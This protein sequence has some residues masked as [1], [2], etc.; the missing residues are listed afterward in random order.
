MTCCDLQTVPDQTLFLGCSILDF[1]TSLQWGDGVSDLNVN[2]VADFCSGTRIYY[3]SC[4]NVQSGTY[5]DLGFVAED[6][7]ERTDGTKYSSCIKESVSDTKLR[8]R[9]EIVGCPVLFKY[10]SF[11]YSG[12]VSDWNKNNSAS[13]PTYR[14]KIVDPRLVLEGV[15]LIIGDYTGSV[16]GTIASGLGGTGEP[17]TNI[18]N[19]YGY[20]EQFGLVCPSYSQCSPG[21]YNLTSVCPTA[22]DG[23]SFGSLVGGF[24]GSLLNN[25]GMP[26]NYII[27]GFNFLANATPVIQ[28]YW[29]PYGRVSYFSNDISVLN[30]SGCGLIEPDTGSSYFANK[31]YY[32][33]DLTELPAFPDNTYRISGTSISLLDLITKASQD[34]NFDFY[35]ELL[36]VKDVST[37]YGGN[38]VAKIIKLRT[39]NRYTQPSLDKICSFIES[40]DCILESS[41]GQE[42]RNETVSKFIIGGKKRTIYQAFSGAN[43]DGGS[44]S[45]ITSID[46]Y[47]GGLRTDSG[48]NEIDDMVLPY[49]GTDFNGDLIV[50]CQVSGVW[51]FAAPTWGIQGELQII[52]FSGAS[53]TITEN[54]LRA[55]SKDYSSWEGYAAAINSD[56][57]KTIY[58]SGGPAIQE[59]QQAATTVAGGKSFL[60]HDIVNPK[61]SKFRENIDPPSRRFQEDKEAIY[62]WIRSYATDFYGR[63]F[64]VRVPFTCV[65][66]DID[67]LQPII[68][69]SPTNDGGW[70]EVSSVLNLPNGGPLTLGQYEYLNFFRDSTNKI[71]PFVQFND[72]VLKSIGNLNK[73][74]Y[75]YKYDVLS[76]S[77]ASGNGPPSGSPSS[78]ICYQ[79]ALTDILYV[80]SF[81]QWLPINNSCVL[82]GSG[83]PAISGAQTPETFCPVYYNVENGDV[84]IA[85]NSTYT[86]ATGVNVGSWNITASVNLYVKAQV[87][88]EYV[89]HDKS[90]YFAPRVV[91]EI[92]EAVK[93]VE[94]TPAY[95]DGTN[96][97]LEAVADGE[98]ELQGNSGIANATHAVGGDAAFMN[99]DYQASLIYAAAIPLEHNTLT[100]GPWYNPTITGRVEIVNDSNLVPWRYNGYTNL[101]L[102]G[103]NLANESRV[104]MY[105]G[106]LGTITIPGYPTIP[107]GAELNAINDGYYSSSEHLIENRSPQ[108]GSVSGVDYNSNL[109]YSSYARFAFPSTW[110]G[111]HGP[112]VTDISV[113]AGQGGFQSTYN[114]R[115]F[116]PR[117]GFFER[118]RANRIE[119]LSVRANKVADI[120]REEEEARKRRLFFEGKGRR[121][122]VDHDVKQKHRSVNLIAGQEIVSGSGKR[123]SVA[124]MPM[125]QGNYEIQHQYAN[126]S[127]MSWDGLLRPF[128]LDGDGGLSPF[129]KYSGTSGILQDDLN[130]FTNP[131]GYSRNRVSTVRNDLTNVGHDFEVLGRSGAD[132]TGLVN[133]AT[134]GN[135]QYSNDYRPMALRGPL[136][137]KGW[138]YD[139][140]GYPVP[141]KADTESAASSGIFVTTGLDANKFLDGHLQKPHTW[142]TAPVDLRFNRD[143][144]VWTI[145]I[146]SSGSTPPTTSGT[147]NVAYV[148]PSGSGSL[149]CS[150]I[151]YNDSCVWAGYICNVVASSGSGICNGSVFSSGTPIWIAD[152]DNCVKIQ[153]L[154]INNRYLGL[155]VSDSFSVSGDTRELWLVKHPT[156]S[157]VNWIYLG[158]SSPGDSQHV[159]YESGISPSIYKGVALNSN[160]GRSTSLIHGLGREDADPTQLSTIAD[161]P[162]FSAGGTFT[163]CWAAPVNLFKQQL[164]RT[165]WYLATLLYENAVING[166]GLPLYYFHAETRPMYNMY[167]TSA[168]AAASGSDTEAFLIPDS[169]EYNGVTANASGYLVFEFDATY[170]IDIV[171]HLNMDFTTNSAVQYKVQT[172][173][174]GGGF[175]GSIYNLNS[176][177][178]G[179]TASIDGA[180]TVV[181]N[182]NSASFVHTFSKGDLLKVTLSNST[183]KYVT[184]DM[185]MILHGPHLWY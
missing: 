114:M 159:T 40:S 14:V 85:G 168:L 101:N 2:L 122:Q 143:R 156:T 22:V 52:N 116:A 6:L 118:Y 88:E 142:V 177:S 61:L 104:N 42:L 70:T 63:K 7:Y 12:I 43:P 185:Q 62:S 172:G 71:T 5:Q 56:S 82:H 84:Y 21:V 20:L 175:G 137:V 169:F 13:A 99:F 167:H 65:K 150:G 75:L 81:T 100:Y 96:K 58:P 4:L 111:S 86:S 59:A 163:D 45:E 131:S 18:F 148:I 16:A 103:A 154:D 83:A 25:E 181:T 87:E 33:V 47:Y 165:G 80:Y 9:V 27:T 8:D 124:G 26:Y 171:S 133:Q 117:R 49:F 76:G 50:P 10:G 60:P 162:S 145:P 146:D 39:V 1:S 41:I 115:T 140:S 134:S 161:G 147:D 3:D 48:C 136:V 15:S 120:L 109:I 19:I 113:Q 23:P 123:T 77:I 98:P 68:S 57:W 11:E 94:L 64:A 164:T 127:F 160:S 166:S 30:G 174:S 38:C 139:I 110:T 108:S 141:N 138:G 176:I 54:E 178:W 55:A 79:D 126:K 152:A 112:N 89:Y 91:V 158:G 73:D 92:P 155:R 69:E 29:S 129:A 119:A 125:V 35:F 74:Y 93:F 183:S 135:L 179:S 34:L 180:P 157:I 151:R 153:R 184:G 36:P 107:L 132:S 170:K 66:V 44:T 90:N 130:P 51:Q 72:A 105:K 106:E 78:S 46:S 173:T 128:S 31:N 144:G 97:A 67:S 102:A 37:I 17:Q 182:T 121:T 24:G 53:I 28:N 95:I 149:G 32:Y